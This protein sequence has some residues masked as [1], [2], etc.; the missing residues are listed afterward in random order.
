MKE[1]DQYETLSDQVAEE[2]NEEIRLNGRL[3]KF[4]ENYTTQQVDNMALEKASAICPRNI[5]HYDVADL[6]KDKIDYDYC[7]D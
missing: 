2:V 1:L 3:S 6:A 5:D 4:G 7:G